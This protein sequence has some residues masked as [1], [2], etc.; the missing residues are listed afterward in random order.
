M[1]T[2]SACLLISLLSV[3]IQAAK[4]E[5]IDVYSHSMKKNVQVVVITPEKKEVP[6]STIY[7]LHGYS[8]NE[9]QWPGIKPDLPEIADKQ[10]MIFVCPDGK[11]VLIVANDSWAVRNIKVQYNGLYASLPLAPGSVGTY[12]WQSQRD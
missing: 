4:I 8:G 10:G 12:I 3:T 1:K 11:I 2:I 7:L 6:S 9:N 5:T